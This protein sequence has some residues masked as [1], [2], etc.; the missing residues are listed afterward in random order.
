MDSGHLVR[1]NSS[2]IRELVKFVRHWPKSPR[3]P[4]IL[5]ALNIRLSMASG[6]MPPRSFLMVD[7]GDIR[8]T[9]WKRYLWA[10]VNIS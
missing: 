6:E 7:F 10:N 4:L 3:P 9:V 5:G 8:F 2:T 1:G